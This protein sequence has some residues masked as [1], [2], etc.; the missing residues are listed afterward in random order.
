M[1]RVDFYLQPKKKGHPDNESSIYYTMRIEG[2]PFIVW[3]SGSWTLVRGRVANS[4]AVG[5]C[6]ALQ[7]S[8][9]RAR[10]CLVVARGRRG[11]SWQRVFRAC[12]CMDRAGSRAGSG[13]TWAFGRTLGGELA[14]QVW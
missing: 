6:R 5:R 10:V 1:S 14:R 11:G 8:V 4:V 13:C 12:V 9:S 2:F 7:F 3:G